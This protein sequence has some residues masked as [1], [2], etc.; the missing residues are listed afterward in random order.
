M[1]ASDLHPYLPTILPMVS[2]P[3]DKVFLVPQVEMVRIVAPDGV[4][5]AEN[6]EYHRRQMC[7][8]ENLL[9]PKVEEDTN[10]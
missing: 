6:I 2:C 5:L 9:V 4:V 8:I 3:R 7:V 10:A 1:S